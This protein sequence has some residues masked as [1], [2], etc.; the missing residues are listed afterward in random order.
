MKINVDQNISA[1][2]GGLIK[3]SPEDETP[4][5]L[6]KILEISCLNASGEK[7]SS[8]EKKHK[9]FKLLQRIHSGG[10]VTVSAEDIVLLKDLVGATYGVGVVGP[11]YEILEAEVE[12]D[13][14]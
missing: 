14:G 10:E 4:I 5:T 1:F 8:G 12:T 2:D 6:A 11:V 3:T 9:V 7:Y 13:D